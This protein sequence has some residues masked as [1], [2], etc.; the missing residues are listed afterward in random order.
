MDIFTVEVM[1]G[2]PY[3]NIRIIGESID[4]YEMEFYDHINTTWGAD[5]YLEEQ[6]D[7]YYDVDGDGNDDYCIEIH[8]YVY[9]T[10]NIKTYFDDVQNI[11]FQVDAR[12]KRT[13]LNDLESIKYK[14][15]YGST[16]NWTIASEAYYMALNG[17]NQGR[18]FK[19]NATT[20][21]LELTADSRIPYTITSYNDQKLDSAGSNYHIESLR[22]SHWVSE[23]IGDIEISDIQNVTDIP[24]SNEQ[25]FNTAFYFDNDPENQE[26]SFAQHKREV[27]KQTIISGLNQAIT[28]YSRNSAGEYKLPQLTETHWDQVLSNVSMIA[29]VQG[30]PIGLKQYNN[31]AI[32]TSTI[33]KEY[34]SPQSIYLTG[35]DDEYYHLPACV[36]FERQTTTMD[37]SGY[38]NID[39][40]KRKKKDSSGY[41]YMH[42]KNQGCYYCIV[43]R[44]LY[45]R[46]TFGGA[47]NRDQASAYLVALARERYI[48]NK[49]IDYE[50][51]P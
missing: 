39:Y 8:N 47:E 29:F 22:F 10:E 2:G 19:Y 11:F 6:I 31:Y 33:N 35:T 46:K 7:Y 45:Q 12:G 34:V 16:S 20:E 23:N 40:V 41:Y 18:W 14:K 26:S 27:I 24:L 37:Y 28:S 4:R 17:T 13:D 5:R 49:F 25:P 3:Y 51:S 1:H 9:D 48:S 30:I 43:Q 36:K 44:A 15:V 32:A 38:R 50:L 21:K 42:E